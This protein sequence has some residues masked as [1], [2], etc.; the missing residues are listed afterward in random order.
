MLLEHY[1]SKENPNIESVQETKKTESGRR[2]LLICK[3]I[4][5][6]KVI[7]FVDYILPNIFKKYITDVDRMEGYNYPVRPVASGNKSVGLYAEALKTAHNNNTSYLQRT[8]FQQ[9]DRNPVQ[10]SN[11][12]IQIATRINE[13]KTTRVNHENNSKTEHSKK[14][15]DTE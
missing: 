8:H 12:R 3:K 4:N 15:I 6:P 7:R 9:L 13:D 11:K 10:R 2:W 14:N 1:L 5:T